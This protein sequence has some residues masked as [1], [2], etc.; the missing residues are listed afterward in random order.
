MR[1]LQKVQDIYRAVLEDFIPSIGLAAPHDDSASC[2]LRAEL[3]LSISSLSVPRT[4][5]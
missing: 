1:F 4:F 3:D 2:L 5:C